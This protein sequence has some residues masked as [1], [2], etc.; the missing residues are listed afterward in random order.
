MEPGLI[1]AGMAVVTY[2]TRAAPLLIGDA[3]E[4]LPPWIRRWLEYLP[5]ALFAAFAVPAIASPALAATPP[6]VHPYPWAALTAGVLARR[7]GNLPR[8]MVASMLAVLL[9]RL[10]LG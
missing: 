5:P 9:W 10:G 6:L 3:A 1:I 4:R 8:A 7:T 2:A